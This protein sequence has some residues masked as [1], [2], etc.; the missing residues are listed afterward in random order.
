MRA[1]S[2]ILGGL[3]LLGGVVSAADVAPSADRIRPLLIGAEVPDAPLRDADGEPFDL[4]AAVK[5]KPA[6]L[7]FYRGGW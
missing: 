7:I 4:L 5:N 3:L 1:K 2:W 6:V